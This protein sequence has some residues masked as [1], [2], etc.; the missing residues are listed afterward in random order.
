[1]GRSARGP[2]E[3]EWLSSDAPQLTEESD[4]G[5]T[6]LNMQFIDG[7]GIEKEV[8]QE[9]INRMLGPEA[10]FRRYERQVRYLSCSLGAPSDTDR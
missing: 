3:S 1:M 8:L 9:S 5:A 4:R 6:A 10:R 2:R 7:D